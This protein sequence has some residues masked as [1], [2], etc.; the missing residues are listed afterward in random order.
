MPTVVGVGGS[1]VSL[2]SGAQNRRGA[3]CTGGPGVCTSTQL[4]PV[5]VSCITTVGGD[6]AVAVTW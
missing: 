4:C 5:V 2:L 1:A 6:P 3:H